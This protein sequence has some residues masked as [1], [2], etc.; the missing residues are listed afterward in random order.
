MNL[1]KRSY[2]LLSFS[3]GLIITLTGC[4]I[5]LALLIAGY[6]PQR[7]KYG[8]SFI[9]NLNNCGFSMG[10]AAFVCKNPSK[11]MLEHEFG[12]SI[13]NCYFGP[14]FIFLVAL[15]SMIRFWY[16]EYLVKSGKKTYSQ[17]PPYD[18]AWFEGGASELG[19]R[20]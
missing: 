13:Q 18:A 4:L 3:W 5:S 17:L 16:R 6:K 15:P 19:S 20:Y 11:H 2:Y 12:H 9:L 10:P 7:N 1:S 14:L 8:W